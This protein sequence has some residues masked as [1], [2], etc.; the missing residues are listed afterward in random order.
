MY[1]QGTDSIIV[2]YS[3]LKDCWDDLDP[4]APQ[5]PR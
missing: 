1:M 2:Y 3:Q 5:P 4:L